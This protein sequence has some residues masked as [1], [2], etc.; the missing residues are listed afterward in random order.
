M[1]KVADFRSDTV[2]KPGPG[3]LTAMVKA[4]V[5]DD[6]Y[7]DDP[8]VQKL[9]KLMAD[10]IGTESALFVSSGTQSN[11]L[12]LLNHCERGDEYITGDQYHVFKYEG[13]GSAALGSLF[14]CP[15]PVEKDGTLSIDLISKSI[16]PYDVHFPPST[17]LCLENTHN[18][19]VIPLNYL[20]KIKDLAKSH[21]LKMH[22]DGARIFNASIA[23]KVDIQEITQGFDSV[24]V[25][26]SKGLGAPIGSVLCSNASFI[27]KARR[28]RKLLGGGMR[29][30][31]IIAAAGIYALENN[32]D[33]LAI[34]HENAAYLAK[35]LAAFSKISIHSAQTNM[36][37]ARFDESID[38]HQLAL[39]L[40][41]HGILIR[42]SRVI[43]FATHLD[44]T[45]EDIK[46]LIQLLKS[47]L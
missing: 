21:R 25:C 4:P 23:S 10:K 44:I 26:L 29:Q 15:L 22:L 13:G 39:Q 36:V 7:Q 35:E 33:R 6:V 16:K 46:L 28:W 14:P 12:A 37:F 27:K 3:M 5:G 42:P 31:G 47:I 18:G 38:V 20:T 1:E 45:K 19:H 43:R 24:S 34:D 2:T 40:K 17:L 30:V 11:L 32:I 41:L 8:T 9:E